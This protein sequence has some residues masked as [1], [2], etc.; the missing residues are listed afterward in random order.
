MESEQERKRGTEQR[1]GKSE[2]KTRHLISLFAVF[3]AG[4]GGGGDGKEGTGRF[5]LSS[6]LFSEA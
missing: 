5:P 6:G 3:G 4:G 2:E 1:G